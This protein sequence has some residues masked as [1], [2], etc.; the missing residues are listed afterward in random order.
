MLSE[1]SDENGAKLDVLGDKET[2]GFKETQDGKETQV[3]N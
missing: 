2:D 1:E 3:Y